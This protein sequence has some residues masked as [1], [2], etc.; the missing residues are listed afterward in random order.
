MSF[1]KPFKSAPVKPGERYQAK[2]ER[3]G[4]QRRT[5]QRHS[6]LIWLVIILVA[7]AGYFITRR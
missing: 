1:K 7:V 4:D 3:D 2:L 6:R 5:A